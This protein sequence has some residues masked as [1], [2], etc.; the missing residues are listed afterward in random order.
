M[1][2]GPGVPR[3][4][5]DRL[6][7]QAGDGG[8]PSP[9]WGSRFRADDHLIEMALGLSKGNLYIG[10]LEGHDLKVKLDADALVQ[11][12]CSILAKTG[13]GKSYT[14]AVVLEELL[15][16]GV[17]LLIIDPHGEYASMKQKNSK[18]S[19][20]VSTSSKEGISGRSSPRRFSTDKKAS[21]SRV[22]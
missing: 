14:A 16:K 12:H 10:L 11:K 20:P 18:G 6:R 19:S 8:R 9:T 13:S 7:R 21:E 4:M 15:E 5:G 2:E 1:R 17:A 3:V 22:D